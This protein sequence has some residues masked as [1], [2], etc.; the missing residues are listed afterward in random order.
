M[1]SE[2]KEKK[3]RGRRPKHSIVDITSTTSI[4]SRFTESD[5][6]IIVQLPIKLPKCTVL[7]EVIIKLVISPR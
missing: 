1:T 2:K 6:N 3:K 5:K 7:F 4:D